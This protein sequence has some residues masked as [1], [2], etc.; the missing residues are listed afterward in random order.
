MIGLRF[1]GFVEYDRPTPRG[2]SRCAS[3]HSGPAAALEIPAVY[4]LFPGIL[5][6]PNG[7]GPMIRL[8]YPLAGLLL[9]EG[10]LVERDLLEVGRARERGIPV[11]MSLSGRLLERNVADTCRE[12]R[13][14]PDEVRPQA[15]TFRRRSQPTR[16]RVRVR[17]DRRPG[18]IL[19]RLVA[20][21]AHCLEVFRPH[22]EAPTGVLLHIRELRGPQATAIL[23]SPATA[24]LAGPYLP[25]VSDRAGNGR[26]CIDIPMHN[27]LSF[28]EYVGRRERGS[29]GE[30][31]VRSVIS[32]P[33][34]V[35]RR[36]SDPVAERSLYPLLGA[37]N[38]ARPVS[39][40]NSK[41]LAMPGRRKL[42]SQVMGR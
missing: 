13:G 28:L 5:A 2:P 33:T 12:H 9:A 17:R 4:P 31:L 3:D 35:V 23:C 18:P 16:R 42:K 21:A 41:L 36:G 27:Y 6:P 40:M 22:V 15:L 37:V 20:K 38:P 25:R 39:P 34:D 11:P 24:L 1:Q 26:I 10:E 14:H 30:G 32:F 19:D 29:R 8:V 7:R